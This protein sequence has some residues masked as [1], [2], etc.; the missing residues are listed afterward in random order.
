MFLI[1]SLARWIIRDELDSYWNHYNTMIWL[2][3]KHI[4]EL[5]KAVAEVN[6]DYDALLAALKRRNENGS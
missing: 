5:E 3:D 2:K 4:A 1:R 6:V